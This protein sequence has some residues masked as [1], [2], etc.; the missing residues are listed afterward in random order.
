MVHMTALAFAVYQIGLNLAQMALIGDLESLA[1]AELALTIWDVLLS[2][3]PLLLFAM[4]G[5]G[6]FTRQILGAPL[7]V[8]VCTAPP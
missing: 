2:G 5:V 1:D 4:I 7:T 6:L 8:W 3:L